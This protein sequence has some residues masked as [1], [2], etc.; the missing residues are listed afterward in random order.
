MYCPYCQTYTH[1]LSMCFEGVNMGVR[2]GVETKAFILLVKMGYIR[3]S[4]IGANYLT[5]NNWFNYYLG[6]KSYVVLRLFHYGIGGNLNGTKLSNIHA[7]NQYFVN[8]W[9]SNEV[10]DL[11]QLLFRP[12]A[13]EPFMSQ[14]FDCIE[15][16]HPFLRVVDN[17]IYYQPVETPLP[18]PSN[19]LPPR[20]QPQQ[21]IP[22]HQL[23]RV[24]QSRPV[25]SGPL[26]ELRQLLQRPNIEL[27]HPV[28]M[29]EGPLQNNPNDLSTIEWDAVNHLS[30]MFDTV[31]NSFSLEEP[32]QRVQIEFVDKKRK[33]DSN[34]ESKSSNKELEGSNEDS[35]CVESLE[36]IE[37]SICYSTDTFIHTDCGHSFCSCIMQNMLKYDKDGCPN[38]RQSITK[39]FIEDFRSY[40]MLKSTNH[41]L[42]SHYSFVE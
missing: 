37:C 5:W 13:I 22:V 23:P 15:L 25:Q 36:S 19:S 3:I 29:S 1:S 10:P 18:P 16:N 41:L 33:R 11:R 8:V 9:N 38:C 40:Q 20:R 35:A 12:I 4:R 32:Q 31:D 39:L 14:L 7:L 26:Q 6:T 27:T 24:H 34:K 30:S 2:F 28:A 42:P 17:K 21:L